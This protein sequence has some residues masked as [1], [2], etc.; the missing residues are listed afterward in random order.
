MSQ[1]ASTYTLAEIIR[2]GRDAAQRE[3]PMDLALDASLAFLHLSGLIGQAKRRQL[4][5][6]EQQ[7]ATQ[8]FSAW[9]A[10]NA[11]E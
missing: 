10:G 3:L 4:S 2:M 5:P 9:L 8:R 7:E 6:Q 11:R 1:P